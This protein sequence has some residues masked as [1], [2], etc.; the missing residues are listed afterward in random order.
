MSWPIGSTVDGFIEASPDRKR[1]QAYM[2]HELFPSGVDDVLRSFSFLKADV[3]RG[4]CPVF[5]S[6]ILEFPT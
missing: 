1:R 6:Q 4:K 5:I 2:P 3:Q